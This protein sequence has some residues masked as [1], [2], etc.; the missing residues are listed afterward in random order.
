[1]DRMTDHISQLQ[2][3]RERLVET[4][5]ELAEAIATTASLSPERASEFTTIQEAISAID[6]AIRDE[7]KHR[8]QRNAS[9]SG[10]LSK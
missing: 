6:E 10:F 3:A 4:R 7:A 5:R 2:K 8:D 1:M 9:G